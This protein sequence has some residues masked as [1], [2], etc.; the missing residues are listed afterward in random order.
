MSGLLDSCL[1]EQPAIRP[2]ARAIRCPLDRVI[3]TPSHIAIR[4]A[5]IR[6]KNLVSYSGEIYRQDDIRR[7][8]H[9]LNR[10]CSWADRLLRE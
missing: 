3:A 5:P 6:E 7:M 2:K 8:T 10:Y 9:H 1:L 4:R